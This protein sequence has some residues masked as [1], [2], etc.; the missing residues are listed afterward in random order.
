MYNYPIIIES[1]W[2]FAKVKFN[3]KEHLFGKTYTSRADL[4]LAPNY[5]EQWNWISKTTFCDKHNPGITISSIDYLLQLGCNTIILSKGYHDV[6]ETQPDVLK[7][8]KN[9]NI[10]I[11]HLTTN[12]AITKWNELT[13]LKD[14]NLKIGMLLHSTC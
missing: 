13:K 9:K 10:K 5:L 7:Y 8:A 12:N 1:E 4:I 14:H 2:N 6:L 3:N 11:Y